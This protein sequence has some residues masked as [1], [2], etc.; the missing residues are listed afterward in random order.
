MKSNGEDIRDYV[1]NWIENRELIHYMEYYIKYYS[2]CE[3]NIHSRGQ[4]DACRIRSSGIHFTKGMEENLKKE[5]TWLPV[6]G[7]CRKILTDPENAQLAID[8]GYTEPEYVVF[9]EKKKISAWRTAF[10]DIAEY[11]TD[12]IKPKSLTPEVAQ[13]RRNMTTKL[14]DAGYVSPNTMNTKEIR[15][16]NRELGIH[17]LNMNRKED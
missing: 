3:A 4:F 16:L 12:K 6:C 8:L 7:R 5:S 11:L 13:D 14:K 17:R 9:P 1:P 10:N 15:K 2:R